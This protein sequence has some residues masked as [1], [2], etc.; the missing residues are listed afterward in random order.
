VSYRQSEA[1]LLAAMF[2]FDPRMS[3]STLAEERRR[4]L[5]EGRSTIYDTTGWNISMMFGLEAF[6]VPEYLD[7]GLERLNLDED[8]PVTAAP[9]GNDTIALVA[10]G[11][12]DRTVA[13]AAR[14]M[15]DSLRVRANTH[16]S[17]LQARRCRSARSR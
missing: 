4:L 2:D 7:A 11:A 12:D 6:E 8:R 9:R 10:S 15:Q 17:Q 14:L 16:P 3:D 13:L 5:A 1:R